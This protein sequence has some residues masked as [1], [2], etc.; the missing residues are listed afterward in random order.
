MK[1][2]EMHDKE[3]VRLVLQHVMECFVLEAS[4]TGWR[5]PEIPKGEKAP[6]GFHWPIAFWNTDGECWM[7]RDI[8]TDPTVFDPP[9]D[10]NDAWQ[11]IDYLD[12]PFYI[13]RHST[14]DVE[15]IAYYAVFGRLPDVVDAQ[16]RT[17]QEAICLAALRAIGI[18]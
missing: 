6:I 13:T 4:A 10:M 15:R 8:A 12:R 5:T 16:A 1:W 18:A 11:T 17:P 7:I 3:R 14:D 2:A 9:H